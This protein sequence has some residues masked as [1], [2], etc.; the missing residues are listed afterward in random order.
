MGL[1]KL[2]P[3]LPAVSLGMPTGAHESALPLN[4]L[5]NK[6]ALEHLLPHFSIHYLKLGNLVI[7]D[8]LVV[9]SLAATVIFSVALL[10]P[11]FLFAWLRIIFFHQCRLHNSFVEVWWEVDV[12]A[13]QENVHVEVVEI[14]VA[15][16]DVLV[17]VTSAAFFG[18]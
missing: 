1:C 5:I 15:F 13:T 2:A 4:A 10:L 6:L 3:F 11:S 18:E 8:K 17:V 9:L 7:V 14:D 12:E 16:D